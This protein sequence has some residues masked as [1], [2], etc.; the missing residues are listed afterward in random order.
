MPAVEQ[1]PRLL[2]NI[3]KGAWVALSHEENR[4]LAYGA[5]FQ[6]VL[7]KARETGEKDPVVIR[8]PQTDGSALL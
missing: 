2:E 8:V 4:V 1:L 7:R 5:E 6:E 3:P